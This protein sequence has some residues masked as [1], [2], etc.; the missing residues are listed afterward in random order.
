MNK[1]VLKLVLIW[2][3]LSFIAIMFGLAIIFKFTNH[4][5]PSIY[6]YESYLAPSIIN[7]LEKNYNYKEFKEISEFTQA[8]TQDKAIAGVGSD[9]QAA[10]LILDKKI[11]KIDFSKVLGEENKDWTKRKKLYTQ[12]VQDHLESFDFL[13]Y[14]KLEKM[15][16]EERKKRGF[17]INK[18]LKR[19][20][21][22]DKN[23]QTE[24]DHF[25]DYIIPYFAQDK[26]I[27][28]NINKTSRPH[29]KVDSPEI[30]D[31][32]N[33]SLELDWMQIFSVLKENKYERVAW[34]NAY[35]DNLMIGAINYMYEKPDEWKK[36]FTT[37]N[38]KLFEF[39]EDNYK[40]A[41]DSFIHFVEKVSGASIKDTS[42][43]FLSGDGLELLNHVIEPKSSR[44]DSG[45]IY[46]G[47]ALDA[48]YSEDNYSSVEEGTIRFIRPK[49]NYVLVD[50]WIISHKLSD[51]DTD[52][53]L[54]SLKEHVYF[55]NSHFLNNKSIQD[56]LHDLEKDFFEVLKEN[57]NAEV[58]SN[59]KKVLKSIFDNERQGVIE[60]LNKN[61]KFK[62]VNWNDF[63]NWKNQ[64]NKFLSND[65]IGD[66][67]T[68]LEIVRNN[69]DE[70]YA[71]FEDAFNDTFTNY[72]FAE[73]ANFDYISYTPADK[74]TYKFIEKWYF[75]NDEIAKSIYSQPAA[76]STYQLFTYPI[77][78]NNLRTKIAAYYYERTRS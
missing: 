28:Y 59:T 55:N 62:L 43:N 38:G 35:V 63:F 46:N 65:T 47:D 49:F 72:H 18:N 1:R 22:I 56:G 5:R 27:A 7:K 40:I 69:S 8:L 21:S 78:D 58:I 76:S 13:I 66:Y 37:D 36:V 61:D 48:Y 15:S 68:W 19:W 23:N 10:Q 20:R 53:F 25:Y 17:E 75:G 9:F 30:Q 29:L 51:E 24:W 4:Y 41:I 11:R 31:L 3:G 12:N 45:V 74:L 77:I 44:S 34:T 16:E 71:L 26:G 54:T 6:N 57:L 33:K 14:N 39:T 64:I 42:H 52:N 32:E 73:L 60:A 70:G 67:W 50:C 2:I